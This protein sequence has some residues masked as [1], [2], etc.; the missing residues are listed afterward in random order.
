MAVDDPGDDV[1]EIGLRVD[2]VELA[3]LDQR[4]DDGPVL[5]AAVGAGEQSV[6]AIERDRP[7]GALDDVVVDLDAAVVEEA[8]QALPARQRVADRLGELGLLADQRE[9]G[10]QPGLRR[11]SA[12]RP[13]PLLAHGAAL[14]GAAAADLVLDRVEAAMRFERLAGDRRGARGASS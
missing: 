5:G 10:A 3:G 9:L 1:G 4:S 13:A 14:L 2:A 6:L 11:P 12:S 7:D 8:R